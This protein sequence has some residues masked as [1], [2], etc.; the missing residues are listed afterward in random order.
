MARALPPRTD[1]ELARL[2][3]LGRRDHPVDGLVRGIL[4]RCAH[5][6]DKLRVTA[7]GN[8]SV[9]LVCQCGAGTLALMM[10]ERALSKAETEAIVTIAQQSEW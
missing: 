10:P 3:E 1:G 9:I 2:L 4:R 8:H 6:A 5:P 7:R